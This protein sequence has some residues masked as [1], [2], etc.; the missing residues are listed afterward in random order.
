[1]IHSTLKYKIM[2]GCVSMN[3]NMQEGSDKKLCRL[4]GIEHANAGMDHVLINRY[5][6]QLGF[7]LLL[8]I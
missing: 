2:C 8:E 1:M 3:R 5:M 6:P 7:I 4:I